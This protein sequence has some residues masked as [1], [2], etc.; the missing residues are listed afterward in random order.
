MRTDEPARQ[1]LAKLAAAFLCAIV[2]SMA[3]LMKIDNPLEDRGVVVYTPQAPEFA[4]TV[5]QLFDESARNKLRPLLPFCL[6]V[7]NATGEYLSGLTAVYRVPDVIMASGRPYRIAIASRT[8]L[9]NRSQMFQPMALRFISPIGTIQGTLHPDGSRGLEPLLD[10]NAETMIAGFLQEFGYR[11][12]DFMIDSI[13]NED[14]VL[15]GPDT[16]GLFDTVNA[17]LKA[18]WDIKSEIAA[19]RGEELKVRLAAPGNGPSQTPPRLAA[20]YVR[21][22]T[23]YS[24]RLMDYLEGVGE[25]DFV[26]TLKGLKQFREIKRGKA[27]SG[28]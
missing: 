18:E 25:A 20:E 3:Q 2:P 7:R 8:V 16:L 28:D 5:T 10:D 19:L 15:E 23:I 13:I 1:P 22:R 6:V 27:V 4:A 17:R 9:E 21:W 12:I 24:R 14:G 11:Q 26:E